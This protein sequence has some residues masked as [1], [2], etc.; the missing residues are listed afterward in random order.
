MTAVREF[1]VTFP[2]KGTEA[3]SSQTPSPFPY[4]VRMFKMYGELAEVINTVET[5]WLPPVSEPPSRGEQPTSE[6]AAQQ[7]STHPESSV[8]LCEVED[9][10]TSV[11]NSLPDSMTFSS[12]KL[13]L[14][15]YVTW[16][17]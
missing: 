5:T 14:P 1:P 12:E 6:E 7:P 9:A 17:D 8:D 2:E 10:I 16:H 15:A 4:F 3:S 11:Y 13:V